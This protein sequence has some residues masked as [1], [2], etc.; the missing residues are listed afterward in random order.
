MM[1][2]IVVSSRTQGTYLCMVSKYFIVLWV[3]KAKFSSSCYA[4]KNSVAVKGAAGKIFFGKIAAK[5]I[6]PEENLAILRL[7]ILQ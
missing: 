4:L 7:K 1:G 6:L 5:L 2:L 3:N